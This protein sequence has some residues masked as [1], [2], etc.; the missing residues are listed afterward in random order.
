M[1]H[2]NI[3]KGNGKKADFANATYIRLMTGKW[4]TY[5][6]IMADVMGIKTANDLPCSVSKCDYY[7]ELRKAFSDV[8]YA[9][10]S[11]VGEDCIEERGNNRAKSFRYIGKD[12]A[13]LIDM[14]NGKTVYDMKH[15][16]Q[17]CQDSTGFFP[18]SWLDFFFKGSR[19]LVEIKKKKKRKANLV[20]NSDIDR[21]QDNIKL[22][23]VLY[24]NI[25]NHQVLS[26]TYKPYNKNVENL[27]FHPHYLKEYNGRWFLLG[28]AEGHTPKFGYTLALDR[29]IKKPEV[30]KEKV[31][32]K[33][34]YAFY[35][36]YFEHIV[37]IG[38]NN[39]IDFKINP[40]KVYSIHI[41]SYSNYIFKLTET[42]KI[43]KTQE[44]VKQFGKH[45]DEDR[46]YGE[47]VVT[48]KVNNEFIGRI[49]QMGA[50]LVVVD[51]PE[52]KKLFQKRVEDLYR[53]YVPKKMNNND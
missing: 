21:K 51:P 42:K 34:P 28:H 24:E 32:I 26:I 33:A 25:I 13:P 52:I 11:K 49:L 30:I 1:K 29:I 19:I 2:H 3:L 27:I 44:T 47:F 39:I 36:D 37:G 17:F 4:I 6:D 7:G 15:Y 53:Q 48:V 31:P 22:F 8:C 5:A 41:R 50:G 23:P 35:S 43:H 20:I 9:I 38:H 40:E 46:K 45:E 16:Y 12:D 18:E 14:E 10:K